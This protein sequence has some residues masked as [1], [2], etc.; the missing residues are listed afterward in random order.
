M[1]EAQRAEAARRTTDR[2]DQVEAT[3]REVYEFAQTKADELS[4]TC[5]KKADYY[6]R[7]MFSG[8][9]KLGKGRRVNPYNAWAHQLA[10]DK[11]GGAL[12]SLILL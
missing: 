1:T 12:T 9:E 2:N 8:G 11:N 3:I 6:L 5:G 7:L 4:Q 10:K